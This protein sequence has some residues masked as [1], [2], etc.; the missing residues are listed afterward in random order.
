MSALKLNFHNKENTV[1]ERKQILS[2]EAVVAVHI[3]TGLFRLNKRMTEML[4]LKDGD[5]IEF[6][7]ADETT[8]F[9][10][11]HSGKGFS[12]K[13]KKKTSGGLVFNNCTLAKK[14]A[15]GLRIQDPS[16]KVKVREQSITLQGHTLWQIDPISNGV[17]HK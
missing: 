5:G 4:A 11:P 1:V 6:A 3:K 9:I 8:W 2:K 16:F 17:A 7:S 12:L 13:E 10:L 15:E 14:I